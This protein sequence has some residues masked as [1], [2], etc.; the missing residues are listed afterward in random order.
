MWGG[1]FGCRPT[2]APGPPNAETRKLVSGLARHEAPN[3]PFHRGDEA[4]PLHNRVPQFAT[5]TA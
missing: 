2:P 4:R 1:D 5:A 3:H